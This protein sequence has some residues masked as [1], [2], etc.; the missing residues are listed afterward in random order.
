M[1]SGRKHPPEFKHEA[2]GLIVDQQLSAVEVSR[3][4]GVSATL[5]Y[6]S[7]PQLATQGEQPWQATVLDGFGV[8]HS[9]T[10]NDY[11][12]PLRVLPN[13]AANRQMGLSA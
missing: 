5:L 9:P 1:P 11:R 10:R 12:N 7:K 4:L 6:E 2:I 3:R 8:R 13:E